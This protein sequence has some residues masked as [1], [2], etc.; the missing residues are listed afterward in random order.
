MAALKEMDKTF[1]EKFKAEI[2]RIIQGVAPQ[3]LPSTT[4]TET[5]QKEKPKPIET[6]T[7]KKSN[8]EPLLKPNKIVKSKS[9][10]S[11]L[12]KARSTLSI[13]KKSKIRSKP[14]PKATSPISP[15]S[16]KHKKTTSAFTRSATQHKL[17]KKKSL[18][19][20]SE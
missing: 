8:K 11:E 13:A 2:M 4:T 15:I 19:K 16:S 1:K 20:T 9:S 17:F 14:K 7:R 5:T 3:N 18:P 12:K 6:K 10:G